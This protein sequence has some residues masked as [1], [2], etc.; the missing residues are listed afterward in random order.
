MVTGSGDETVKLWDVAAAVE[1]G[2][3]PI[4]RAHE[5]QNTGSLLLVRLVS[6]ILLVKNRIGCRDLSYVERTMIASLG[7]VEQ[8][9][10]RIASSVNTIHPC[11]AN[12]FLGRNPCLTA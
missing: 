4:S 1:L 9:D 12:T 10:K 2:Y 8:L 5:P 6:I 7:L 3:L 11:R